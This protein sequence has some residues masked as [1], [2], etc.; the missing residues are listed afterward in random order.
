MC[1]CWNGS[2]GVRE[3][4]DAPS[5]GEVWW[6]PQIRWANPPRF[7]T[8]SAKAARRAGVP[9]SVIMAI[10]GRKTPSMI[11]RYAIVSSADQR[12]AIEMIARECSLDRN[13]A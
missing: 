10:G 7:S 4:W 11:R 12:S 6:R 8:L 1:P 9:E 2:I 3:V 13:V 5:R